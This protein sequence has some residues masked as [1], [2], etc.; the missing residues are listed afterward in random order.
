VLKI[1][2]EQPHLLNLPDPDPPHLEITDEMLTQVISMG[3]DVDMARA[4]LNHCGAD[5]MR[6]VDELVR[7]GGI[8]PPA[9]LQS[10][11]PTSATSSS[12]SVDC[13]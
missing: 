12:A 1:L 8:V 13:K 10:L 3:F 9:W 2:H 4:A 6:A 11:Q 5:I 7:L